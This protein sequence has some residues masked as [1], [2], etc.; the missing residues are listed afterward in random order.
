MKNLYIVANIRVSIQ[1]SLSETS[2]RQ[3]RYVQKIV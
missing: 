3:K 1:I 2:Y